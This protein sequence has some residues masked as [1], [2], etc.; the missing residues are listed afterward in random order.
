MQLESAFNALTAAITS[1]V[2][3][4]AGKFTLI[5]L[6]PTSAQSRCFPSTY[7]TD[8]GSL[9]TKIVPNP[10]G[11]SNFPI[12]AAISILIFWAKALPSIIIALMQ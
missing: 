4:V 2:V 1:S 8:P 9:P 11:L 6:I 7:A 10:T 12:A 3:E 5:D